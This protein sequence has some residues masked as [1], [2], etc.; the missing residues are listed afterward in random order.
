MI[1]SPSSS[2]LNSLQLR[3]RAALELRRR[4]VLT[5]PE[6]RVQ[7]EFRGAVA[8]LRASREHEVMIS[9]PAETGKTF[10]SLYLLHERMLATPG[11]SAALVR[12]VRADMDASVLNTWRRVLQALPAGVTVYGGNKPEWYS[13]PN[14]SIVYVGGMDRPGKVLSGER[15]Y[16]YVNQAEELSSEDWQTLTTRAT[17]RG[18]VAPYPQVF[19]DCNPGP[20][21]HWIKHRQSL[22]LLE[23]R[24]EDNP[25]LFDANGQLTEQGKRTMAVLDALEGVLKERLRYGRWVGAEGLVYA[26]DAALHLIDP[27]PIPPEWPRIR[28]IDFGF[29]NPFVCLWL[30]RD[31]DARLYL[32]REIYMSQRTVAEHALTIHSLSDGER[33]EATIADHDAEDRAT[34]ARGGI[35]T[36]AAYKALSPGIQA[37]QARLRKAGDGRPRLFV[38]KECLVERDTELLQRRQPISTVQEFDAYVWPK[39]QDGK[40]LKEVPM[41][42]YNHA[43]DAL[44]YGVAYVDQIQKTRTDRTP[45]PRSA[46]WRT[47]R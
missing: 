23:S 13:Y 28:V 40:V 25:S 39:A 20:P 36:L 18:G 2:V 14:G 29:T 43:M 34:L 9:G 30:A 7:P 10:G 24:H 42:M 3:A 38:F 47:M 8:Q 31:S 26:F 27:F 33:I 19:G 35:Q 37:V 12:K 41:D 11:A 46:S 44:R 16:I 17:G 32:Y 45:P 4:A 15:D 22:R 6:A 5:P 21:H 1:P